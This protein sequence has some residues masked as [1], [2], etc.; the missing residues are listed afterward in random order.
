[1]ALAEDG[2]LIATDKWR[3]VASLSRLSLPVGLALQLDGSNMT[4]Q[5]MIL[6][7]FVLNRLAPLEGARTQTWVV[8]S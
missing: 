1:M 7:A 3:G 8:M 4:V 2:R 5:E 6:K